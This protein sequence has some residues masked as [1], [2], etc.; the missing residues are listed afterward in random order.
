[1]VG[2]AKTAEETWQNLSAVYVPKGH[3]IA[4]AVLRTYYDTHAHKGDD[5]VKHLS[6][7]KELWERLNLFSDEAFQISDT[8]F[9]SHISSSLPE[10]WDTFTECYDCYDLR[11]RNIMIYNHR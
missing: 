5:I 4:A 11:S 8:T 1:M 3:Q 6:K 9:K 10:S 2:R 7:L